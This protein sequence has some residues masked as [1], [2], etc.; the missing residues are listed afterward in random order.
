[1]SR[2]KKLQ[3]HP[4][5]IAVLSWVLVNY[6]R[7]VFATTR[8]TWRGRDHLDRI[9]HG[10][11]GA[12][13]AFWHNRLML[14]PFIWP[15][16]VPIDM[17]ISAHGDG[18]IVSRVI[19]RLGIGTVEGSTSKGGIKALKA[20]VDRMKAGRC[21]AITPD[22]PRGPRMRASAGVVAAARLAGTPILPASLS[23]GNRKVLGSWDRF[24]FALP[25]GRGAFVVGDPIRVPRQADEAEMERLRLLVETRLTELS[26]EA[27]R[28]VGAEP[29][30]PAPIDTKVKT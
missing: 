23:V 4:I 24:I 21:V 14:M 20:V 9:A 10:S 15:K 13:G 6:A 29:I 22:G 7:L 26:D 11:E 8:W 5:V 17:M 27:D 2:R 16:S 1:M 3:N 19:G 18:R 28:L 30:A 25:F 12:I